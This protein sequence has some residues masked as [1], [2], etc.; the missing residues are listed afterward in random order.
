M[1]LTLNENSYLEVADADLYFGDRLNSTAW[2]GATPEDKAK[3]LIG[4][5]KA[6]ETMKF[7][8][9]RTVSTQKL[10]FPRE[11]VYVDGILIDA[12]VVPQDIKDAVCEYAI[13][14]LQE[15]YTAPDDLAQ[16]GEV[17]VGSIKIKTNPSKGGK[18]IPPMVASLLS[19]YKD[20]TIRIVRA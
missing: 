12:T 5:T 10:S 19:N 14:M 2:T 1:A 17:A 8:G 16:F 6:I 9:S 20:S 15:D 3:A 7:I 11:G 18:A 4:A 13:L